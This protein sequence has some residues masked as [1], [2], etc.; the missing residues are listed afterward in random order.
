MSHLSI[1]L[2]LWHNS[3]LSSISD[4]NYNQPNKVIVLNEIH[5]PMI[6][7]LFRGWKMINKHYLF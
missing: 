5:V 3:L 2:T 1:L 7:Q 6:S 4:S